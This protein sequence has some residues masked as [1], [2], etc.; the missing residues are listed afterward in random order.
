M[1]MLLR[2]HIELDPPKAQ[3]SVKA[4]ATAVEPEIELPFTDL[5]EEKVEPKRGRKPKE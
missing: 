5:G 4:K 1:G 3:K 2:R